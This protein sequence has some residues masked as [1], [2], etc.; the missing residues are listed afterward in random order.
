M[1][2]EPCAGAEF[3]VTVRPLPASLVSTDGAVSVV[4]VGV[5]PVFP[6]AVGV[7]VSDTL[8]VVVC[9]LVS[10]AVYVNESGPLYPPTGV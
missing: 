8:A 4:F 3:A 6:T 2:S 1:A 5:V 7:T 10:V 9:P